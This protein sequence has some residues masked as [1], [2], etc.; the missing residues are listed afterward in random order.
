[1]TQL[2]NPEFSDL[3]LAIQS[4]VQGFSEI[5]K[6]SKS[7]LDSALIKF[8][9]DVQANSLPQSPEVAHFLKKSAS[10]LAEPITRPSMG[11]CLIYGSRSSPLLRVLTALYAL[12]SRCSV[13][14]LCNV[15]LYE[16]YLQ[17]FEKLIHHGLPEKAISLVCTSDQECLETLISHPSLKAIHF[18]G[19]QYEGAFLKNLTLP[20]FKK[21]IRVHLGGRNPVIFMHDAPLENLQELISTALNTTYLAEHQFN[22]WFVQE[23]NFTAFTKA[24]ADLLSVQNQ[25]VEFHPD[26]NNCSPLHQQ[27]ML[28]PA[29]TVTRFKN[30]SEAI[31]FANTTNYASAG[32]VFSGNFE[33]S[34]EIANQLTMPHRFAQQTPDMGAVDVIRGLSETGF[35]QDKSDPHFFTA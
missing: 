3:I 24:I 30:S 20:V 34:Q 19:H 22:R 21:R 23:K 1:M 16:T 26:F 28:G 31:K 4:T 5:Q 7:Q 8:V 18:N 10:L 17:L 33:K 15:S 12:K 14:F 27:E 11:P 2:K 6:I 9:D 25:K 32:A 13:V 35:G 29:L